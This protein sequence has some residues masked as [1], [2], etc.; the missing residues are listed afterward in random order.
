MSNISRAHIHAATKFLCSGLLTYSFNSCLNLTAKDKDKNTL[1][2]LYLSWCLSNSIM[3]LA[4]SEIKNFSNNVLKELA[5]DMSLPQ[6]ILCTVEGWT[7]N[8]LG[9]CPLS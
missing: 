4:D 7:Q 3:A 1:S 8:L 9:E 5:G 6:K 2:K